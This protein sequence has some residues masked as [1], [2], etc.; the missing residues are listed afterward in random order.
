MA[1]LSRGFVLLRSLPEEPGGSLALSAFQN[2]SFS[3]GPNQTEFTS[4]CLNVSVS[5]VK[6]DL[7]LVVRPA[8]M[9]GYFTVE[10]ASHPGSSC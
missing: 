4:K 1:G 9:L 2:G 3:A 8:S 10:A 6:L 5:S 7:I